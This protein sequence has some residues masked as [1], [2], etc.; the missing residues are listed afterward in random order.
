[1]TGA[2]SATVL[3][4]TRNRREDL[5]RA[6]ASAVA[7]YDLLEVLVID[8]GSSDG[9]SA[10]VESEFP[11][12]RLVSAPR[13]LGYIKQRN[14]GALLARGTIV[15]SIDDDA[16]FTSPEIVQRTLAEFSDLRIGAVA[17][18]YVNI[19]Q[20]TI[21]RQRAADAR[22]I[23]VTDS[24]VGTAHAVRRDLFLALGGYRGELLHQGEE[25]E[26][27]LRLLAAGYVVRMGFANVIHHF[28]SPLR[29]FRRM[30]YFGARNSLLTLWWN[31]PTQKL[32]LH[33]LGTALQVMAHGVKI[34]QFGV[35]C[36]A[37]WDGFCVGVRGRTRRRPVEKSVYALSKLLRRCKGLPLHEAVA[38]LPPMKAIAVN[39]E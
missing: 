33:V 26:F 34:G 3:I 15:I 5:R 11:S 10:M 12:V 24:Y 39:P 23:T 1:M 9:T 37:L 13:S 31:V 7:Q 22:E 18:P 2:H 8:D 16:V 6:I 17:I 30:H 35:K 20:D 29:D 32:L 21:V 27:C 14:N 25:G 4:T 28:E 38:K 36:R 19:R